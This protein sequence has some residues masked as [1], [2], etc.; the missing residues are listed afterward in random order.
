MVGI[1]P[2]QLCRKVA[3]DRTVSLRIVSNIAIFA[4]VYM[5]LT[6]LK[7]VT[8]AKTEIIYQK[9]VRAKVAMYFT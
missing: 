2:Y 5:T 7:L 3:S 9:N 4:P 1:Y 6:I 8:L